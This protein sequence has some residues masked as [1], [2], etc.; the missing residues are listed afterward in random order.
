MISLAKILRLFFI[1]L[2][3]VSGALSVFESDVR[4][5]C[6]EDVV[7][8]FIRTSKPFEGLV[9]TR[10]SESE[11]CRVQGFGTNVAVL[12]LNL[13]SDECGIKYD[14]ASKTYSVT[15]D[16]HSHPVLIVEG[17]KSVN[18]TCREIANGTQHY[19][20]QM[21]SQSSDYQLRVLSSRLPVDTVKYSQ[22]YT[23]QIRPL[24]STQQNS[25]S[26]FVGQCIAQPVGGNVTVQ[27]TD[28]V[29]CALFKS[30]MGH[31][32]RRES[33]EE[34][35]IPSMFR[36][37]NAKQ[38]KISCIVTE[39]DGSCE[40]RT[41]DQD[42]SASSLLERTT[43]SAESEEFQRVSI[44]VNLEEAD[45]PVLAEAVDE[46]VMVHHVARDAETPP[47]NLIV[48]KSR[49]EIY[50]TECVSVNEFNLL[51]YLCIFLAV[52][53]IVG[54]TMNIVLALML[55]RR[56][57]KKSKRHSIPVEQLQI[58]KSSVA[59]PDF[60][61]TENGKEEQEP[62]PSYYAP[63]RDSFSSY[64]SKP[65]RRVIPITVASEYGVPASRN[66]DASSEG[67]SSNEIYRRPNQ[68]ALTRPEARHSNST[69]M[70]HSTT[71][72]TDLDSQ[73]SN[74]ATSYH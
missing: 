23:L 40:A 29:G 66:S 60:W 53:S 25:Y 7:S 39:C 9:Q 41:C 73:A 28:P 5:S 24:P 27:L 64:A 71:M 44:I 12:K 18:V 55:K 26:F 8:V 13:K 61:I 22:P 37:P 34:A 50:Q 2:P 42:S 38:L 19:A 59:P 62:E 17:D 69:F 45:L 21:T 10:S 52:C 20:S 16:V 58:P 72:E 56:S 63:R 11:A 30:I 46:P 6:S 1:V 48:Q 54:F 33:V 3:L 70:T 35:E 68:I 57:A 67:R 32:A 15:V 43:A 51:Y 49:D 36:F 14:V 31:F 47:P 65:N 4:W 74:Q